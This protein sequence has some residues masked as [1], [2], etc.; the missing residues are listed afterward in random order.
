[1]RAAL[2]GSLYI[3]MIWGAAPPQTAPENMAMKVTVDRTALY[4][5]DRLKYIARVEH[6]SDVEFVRDH[7]R[8]DQLALEPFEVLDVSTA[9]GDLPGG[10]KFFE[11]KLLLTTYDTGHPDATVPSFNLFYFRHGQTSG[12]DTTPAE[13]MAV[14]P[15]KIG[16]RSTIVDLPGNIRADQP[17]IPVPRVDWML[18]GVVGLCGLVAVVLYGSSAALRWM[19]SG[20]WKRKMGE[21][22]RQKSMRESFEEIRRTPVDSREN[23]ESFY[24]R[25]SA[26]LRGLAAEQLG[27]C[28]GLTPREMRAAL[29]Q[30]GDREGHAIAVGDLMEQCDLVRYSSDGPERAL[31]G[32]AEFLRKFEDLVERR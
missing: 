25:A 32:H 5:G 24:A 7:V 30:A 17:I 31:S 8:K 19:R 18:P 28:G 15:L 2:L 11:V 9:T 20:F 21:R 26:I 27:D 3:G 6:S 14:P 12:K 16:L 10:R 1:M 22:V 23:A 4:P 13:T 29:Q